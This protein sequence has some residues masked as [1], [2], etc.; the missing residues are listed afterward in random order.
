KIPIIADFE[1]NRDPKYPEL[2]ALVDNLILSQ[3][4]AAEL[5]GEQNPAEAAKK[6]WTEQREVV[7]ITCGVDG[8]WYFTGQDAPQH[9]PA[10]PVDTVDSTGC[11]DVFHGAYA[12]TLVRG[13]NVAERVRFAAAAA[14]IK[15]T[16][17]GGQTGIPRWDQVEAFLRDRGSELP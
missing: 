7:C 16:Q 15:A 10:F 5:S 12:A 17:P 1:S 4:Y 11:G 13:F 2:L 3:H 8:A 6:L 14:A 9:Q